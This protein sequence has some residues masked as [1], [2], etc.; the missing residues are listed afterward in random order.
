MV[1]VMTDGRDENNA[2]TGPGSVHTFEQVLE[3][4]KSLTLLS[5]Q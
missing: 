1:V 4:L 3:R 5:F 2:G